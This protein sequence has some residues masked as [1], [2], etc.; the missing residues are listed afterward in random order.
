MSQWAAL[1]QGTT[2]VVPKSAGKA[3][4]LAPEGRIS[5]TLSENRSFS[6]ACLAPEG[7]LFHEFIPCAGFGKWSY[8]RLPT[9]AEIP[10]FE[11]HADNYRSPAHNLTMNLGES[12]RPKLFTAH[13]QGCTR[14]IP[15]RCTPHPSS[16][17]CKSP[18][19]PCRLFLTRLE[20]MPVE[21]FSPLN[22]PAS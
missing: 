5:P 3:R 18:S 15:T 8:L 7:G 1:Y 12:S 14:V 10:L 2:S 4:A 11:S 19:K 6:A 9:I 21:N 17:K 20:S 13:F 16:K 22:S